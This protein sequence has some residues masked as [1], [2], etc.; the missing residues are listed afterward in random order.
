MPWA[1]HA[2]EH[3]KCQHQRKKKTQQSNS[4]THQLW[5][6]SKWFHRLCVAGC[7]LRNPTTCD[8]LWQL[9]LVQDLYWNGSKRSSKKHSFSGVTET[10]SWW[11]RLSIVALIPNYKTPGLPWSTLVRGSPSKCKLEDYRLRCCKLVGG[12]IHIGLWWWFA[13]REFQVENQWKRWP[14]WLYRLYR[15]QVRNPISLWLQK[16]VWS[17]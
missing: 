15:D 7:Y 4:D 17:A 1:C 8:K 6:Y 9:I 14:A 13:T 2:A 12:W 10:D 11:K 16:H 3:I 5:V